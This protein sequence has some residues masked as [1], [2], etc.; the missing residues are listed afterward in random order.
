MNN[1]FLMEHRD[2]SDS[3][4]RI[5]R[6]EIKTSHKFSLVTELNP[7]LSQYMQ[8]FVLLSSKAVAIWELTG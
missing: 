4:V 1:L 6:L 7:V 2:F 8:S 5:L 3:I